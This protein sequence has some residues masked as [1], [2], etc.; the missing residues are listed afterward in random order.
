MT[1]W[2]H[3]LHE[4][5]LDA[6]ALLAPVDCAGCSAPD[7][8]L[9]AAC[10]AH[11]EPSLRIAR[12]CSAGEPSLPV[13]AGLAYEGVARSAL[14]ALKEEG[15]TELARALAPALLVA[16]DRGYA[17]AAAAGAAGAA[18]AADVTGALLVPVPGSPAAAR[19]RGFHPAALLAR[20]AGLQPVSILRLI[21]D[22]HGPQK[23]RRLNERVATTRP[24]TARCRLDGRTVIVLDDVVTS[25]ATLLAAARALR[26]AGA[27]VAG[28]VALAA[29]PRRFGVAAVEWRIEGD[30]PEPSPALPPSRFR[31]DAGAMQMGEPL[32]FRPHED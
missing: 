18:G 4:A 11:L 32:T 27:V 23:S 31:P 19:R 26:A 14:L 29:T 28:A 16:V 21:D 22:G 1:V 12:L 20:R 2:A 24:I 10:R 17:A 7:R 5:A 30:E 6:L 25:G 15:R 3:L 9:C 8:A 13:V